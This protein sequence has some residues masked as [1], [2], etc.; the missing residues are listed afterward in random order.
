[1]FV[2]SK[3]EL[4]ILGLIVLGSGIVLIIFVV[5]VIFLIL[6]YCSG[7]WKFGCVIWVDEEYGFVK[8]GWNLI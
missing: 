3:K 6:W 8:V 4:F 5:I 7:G 1:M 2:V